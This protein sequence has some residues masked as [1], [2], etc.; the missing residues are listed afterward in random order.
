MMADTLSLTD[1]LGAAM[2]GT[3]VT[4]RSRMR[5]KPGNAG[6]LGCD[7]ATTFV[8]DVEFEEGAL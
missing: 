7:A 4:L 2:R 8:A 3:N 1:T 6:K 5:P